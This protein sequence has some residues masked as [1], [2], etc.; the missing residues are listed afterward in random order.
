MGS[1]TTGPVQPRDLLLTGT[2][3]DGNDTLFGSDGRDTLTGLALSDLI[4]GGDGDDFINGGF[5]YDRVNGGTGA[6]RFYYLGV[7]DHGSDWIQDYAARDGDVLVYGAATSA[8]DF[9]V[10][11]AETA[12]AGQDGIE[13]VFIT[14]RSTGVLLWA[15]V[16]GDAQTALNVQA[17]GM[18]FDPLA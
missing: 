4:F 11:V 12:N 18:T 10:Q 2:G 6:D 9:L 15:L 1:A 14:H 5:G 8:G 3:G 13:E 7:A 17:A 16:E